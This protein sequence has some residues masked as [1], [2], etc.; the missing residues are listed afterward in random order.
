MPI[1]DNDNVLVTQ[2]CLTD[3]TLW[4]GARQAPLSMAR[5]LE[6]VAI[7]FSRGASQPKDR[8]CIS[9]ISCIGRWIHCAT[10]EA[11]ILSQKA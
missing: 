2:L 9:C 7:S 1:N 11:P 8:T 3:V 6:Q 10:S 5:I 4:T